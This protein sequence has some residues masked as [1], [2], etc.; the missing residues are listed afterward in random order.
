M[1]VRRLAAR[2]AH[3]PDVRAA[4]RAVLLGPPRSTGLRTFKI[5]ETSSA[6][7]VF[8]LLQV[9]AVRNAFFTRFDQGANE[10][11]GHPKERAASLSLFAESWPGM[12]RPIVFFMRSAFTSP[13]QEVHNGSDFR[14]TGIEELRREAS[15]NLSYT[16]GL[17]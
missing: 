11:F 12:G 4:R 7:R 16:F 10:N 14:G 2:R 6:F 17:S 9:P 15:W 13:V 5:Q 8:R 3:V 1:V